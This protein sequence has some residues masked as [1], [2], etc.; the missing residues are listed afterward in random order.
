MM[1]C[2][3]VNVSG[4]LPTLSKSALS[5]LLSFLVYE[6]ALTRLRG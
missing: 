6:H 3:R 4:G 5:S 1:A 2:V